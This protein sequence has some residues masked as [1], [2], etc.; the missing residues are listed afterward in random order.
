[1]THVTSPKA[2]IASPSKPPRAVKVHTLT[3]EQK[4]KMYTNRLLLFKFEMYRPEV[5]LMLE[6]YFQNKMFQNIDCKKHFEEVIEAFQ[7]ITKVALCNKSDKKRQASRKTDPGSVKQLKEFFLTAFK[8]KHGQAYFYKYEFYDG[9]KK[10]FQDQDKIFK[11][12]KGPLGDIVILVDKSDDFERYLKDGMAPQRQT[13]PMNAEGTNEDPMM[14]DLMQNL[15]TNV[16]NC[17][18]LLASGQVKDFARRESIQL[19]INQ[20][21]TQIAEL[22]RSKLT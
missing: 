1:M 7:N 18:K 4:S 17:E 15:L 2:S 12:T 21:N 11:S 6:R 14:D 19:M 20:F 13:S 22:E 3:E 8:D 16:S 9:L 5:D 10:F